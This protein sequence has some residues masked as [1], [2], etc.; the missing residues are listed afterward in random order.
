MRE[1]AAVSFEQYN[2]VMTSIVDY[3]LIFQTEISFAFNSSTPTTPPLPTT[4][5]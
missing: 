3:I 5:D 1:P 2:N 4:N